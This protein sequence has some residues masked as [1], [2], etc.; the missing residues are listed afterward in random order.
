MG[1]V[2][3]RSRAELRQRWKA[4]LAV[5]LLAGIGGGIAI[6]AFAA[7]D[8]VEQ[9]YPEFVEAG[10]PMDVLVPGANP[11][12]L[13]GGVELDDVARLPEVAETADAS[14]NL[15]FAGSTPD[16]RL[17]GPGDVFPVA[18]AGNALGTTFEKFTMLDG[19][20]ARP[21]AAREVTASFV[22]AEKLGL[23]VGDTLRLHFFTAKNYGRTAGEVAHR[24]R[25]SP[26]FEIGRVRRAATPS[27]PT[28][29]TSGSR[30]WGSR[31]PPASSRPSRPT[32][33]PSCT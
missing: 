33:R 24:V 8:R 1:A 19:R 15:L 23:E 20:A 16:G 21:F 25:A 10:H 2:W 28:A 32:S 12:G 14:A 9:T 13:V 30:S 4:W 31:P 6:G 29:L 17:I 22:A 27:S 11:F 5:A 26:R 3:L 7:A 18:A